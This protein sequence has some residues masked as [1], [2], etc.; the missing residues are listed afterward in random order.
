MSNETQRLL[1]NANMAVSELEDIIRKITNGPTEELEQKLR[2]LRAEISTMY[3]DIME[4]TD[5]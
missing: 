1:F 3:A 4:A 2:R 5:T